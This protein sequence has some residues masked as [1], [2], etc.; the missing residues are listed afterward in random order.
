MVCENIIKVIIMYSKGKYEGNNLW[1]ICMKEKVIY[2]GK[3]IDRVEK[4]LLYKYW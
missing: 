4:V 3:N 1:Y 2:E